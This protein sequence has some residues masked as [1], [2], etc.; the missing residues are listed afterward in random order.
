MSDSIG[1]NDPV[2]TIVRL[3]ATAHRAGATTAAIT[4]RRCSPIAGR[5]PA[6]RAVAAWGLR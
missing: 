6:R 2:T 5:L 1:V 3:A 4:P